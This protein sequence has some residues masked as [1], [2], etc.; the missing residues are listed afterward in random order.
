MPFAVEE[1]SGTI[2]VVD[3]LTKYDRILYDF[4][5][6]V[7]DDDTIS[8]VTNVTINVVDFDDN[9]FIK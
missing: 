8:L 1:K 6:V 2:T 5:A 9:I 7:T 4:E 3:E